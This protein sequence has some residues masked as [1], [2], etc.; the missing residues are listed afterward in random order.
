VQI[1][2]YK[3]LFFNVKIWYHYSDKGMESLHTKKIFFIWCLLSPLPVLATGINSGVNDPA[4]D[5]SVMG[6]YSGN[7]ALE[8]EYEAN[9]IP[10]QWYDNNEEM[11]VSSAASSC[12][13]G[14][15]VTVAQNPPSRTGYV[16]LGWNLLRCDLTNLNVSS[17]GGS[18]Y[19]V[20]E[21]E[22]SDF[23][24]ITSGT[25]SASNCSNS[26]FD[27]LDRYEWKTA[28]NSYGVVYGVSKCTNVSG[29][30]AQ[31]GT[32][33]DT[34]GKNCWCKATKYTPNGNPQCVVSAPWVFYWGGFNGFSSCNYY[35]AERCANYVQTQQG[36]RA[37]VFGQT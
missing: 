25:G 24:Y 22:N 27:D 6:T 2:K 34:N 26:A 28:F 31:T 17:Y 20:A 8:A 18:Y 29:T 14:G 30:Y 32:P 35:C 36:F 11:N 15:N 23:C 5:N 10:I 16:F 1:N 21:S 3:F 19:S 33:G 7:V 37:A 12:D 9:G 13:Y 4:C